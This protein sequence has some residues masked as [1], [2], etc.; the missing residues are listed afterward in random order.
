MQKPKAQEW[1]IDLKQIVT[2][3][4]LEGLTFIKSLIK[5]QFRKK[6]EY[7]LLFIHAFGI[8]S[9]KISFSVYHWC[10]KIY[11]SKVIPIEVSEA[12][13]PIGSPFVVIKPMTFHSPTLVLVG[14]VIYHLLILFAPLRGISPSSIHKQCHWRRAVIV[15]YNIILRL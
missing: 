1:L 6:V 8:F 10:C 11:Q 4:D 2:F 12:V 5:M 15:P 3:L 9:L 14:G 7:V 13:H